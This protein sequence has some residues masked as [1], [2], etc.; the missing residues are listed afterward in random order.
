MMITTLI[1]TTMSFRLE[2]NWLSYP[3]HGG[4]HLDAPAHFAQGG[5]HLHELP[6]ERFM[7]RAVVVDA[8]ERAGRDADYELGVGQLRDWED[9]HGNI[10]SDSVLLVNFGWSGRWSDR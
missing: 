2:A 4:T 8:T 6:V 5:Q 9:T 7:G 1:I 3:E 10:P